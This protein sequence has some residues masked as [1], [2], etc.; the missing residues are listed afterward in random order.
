MEEIKKLIEDLKDFI[1]QEFAE[2]KSLIQTLPSLKTKKRKPS[3]YQKFMSECIKKET[4][5]IQ[6][7]FQKC[8]QKWKERK[9]NAQTL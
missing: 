6:E 2:V 5:L 4:G 7:R 8:V 1:K 9:K 3:E